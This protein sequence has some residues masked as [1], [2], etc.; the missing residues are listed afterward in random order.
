MFSSQ[1]SCG[2]DPEVCIIWFFKKCLSDVRSIYTSYLLL[3]H[4]LDPDPECLTGLQNLMTAHRAFLIH[5]SWGSRTLCAFFYKSGLLPSLK[6]MRWTQ[7]PPESTKWTRVPLKHYMPPRH[8]ILIY[9]FQLNS[10]ADLLLCFCMELQIIPLKLLL[11]TVVSSSQLVVWHLSAMS[12]CGKAVLS[13]LPAH[14]EMGLDSLLE[15]HWKWLGSDICVPKADAGWIP[16]MVDGHVTT[17]PLA[18]AAE[19]QHEIAGTKCGCHWV[20]GSY[21]LIRR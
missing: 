21:A 18:G 19:N 13:L 9:K 3:L 17:P 8:Y 20:T 12:V 2:A 15:C 16:H 1:H 6:W 5:C 14:A 4:I 7:V 11:Q 10:L